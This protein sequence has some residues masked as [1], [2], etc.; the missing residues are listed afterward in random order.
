MRGGHQEPIDGNES[1]YLQVCQ[2]LLVLMEFPRLAFPLRFSTLD[3]LYAR[4]LEE[5]Y[6]L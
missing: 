5:D 6:S 2:T 1:G 4:F 3:F